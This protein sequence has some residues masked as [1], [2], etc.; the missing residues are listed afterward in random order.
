M[1]ADDSDDEDELLDLNGGS[2]DESKYKK[3]ICVHLSA[4][5]PRFVYEL[6]RKYH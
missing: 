1:N 4:V 6:E 3:G 2:P 5:Q